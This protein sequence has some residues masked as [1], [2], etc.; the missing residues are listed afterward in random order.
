MAFSFLIIQTASLGDVILSTPTVEKIH[1]FFP[2]SR[3]DFLT[4]K[5][6]EGLFAGHPYINE[7][8]LWN[9]KDHKYSNLLKLLKLIRSKRYDYVI[10]L[11]RHCSTGLLTAMSRAKYTIGFDKNPLHVFFT[12]SIKHQ[13]GEANIH[14]VHRNLSL[15]EELTDSSFQRPVLRPSATDYHAIDRYS[16]DI[17]Y[18]LAPCSLWNTKQMPDSLWIELIQAIPS[19]AVVYLLGSKSDF[20]VCESIASRCKKQNIKNLAGQL[21]LLESAALMSHAKMNFTNDS[22]P[23]HL[24]SAM[25]APVTAIF[26]STTIEFGFGP[27]SDDSAVVETEEPLPC[28]PCGI[29][30]H[31]RC[32][33]GHYLCGY[34][35]KTQKLIERL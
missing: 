26:C 32:P 1:L 10:N 13:I 18:C 21:S 3:I 19:N 20:E 28:R 22:S 24:A 33:K 9:K 12:K 35:I 11:Q 4:K 14:E 16:A 8:L 15:I 34:N 5:G 25:N 29:H 2:D 6:N 31:K 27:L 23:M 30:G 7:L 17:Y